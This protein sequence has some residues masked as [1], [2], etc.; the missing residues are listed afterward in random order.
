MSKGQTSQH[1]LCIRCKVARIAC[2]CQLD[3]TLYC[4]NDLVLSYLEKKFVQ[5]GAG[6]QAPGQ[7]AC[8]DWNCWCRVRPVTMSA[9]SYQ[10]P[11]R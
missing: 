9:S 1:V 8:R 2:Q 10:A 3:K 4:V 6:R 7:K 5:E 11:D